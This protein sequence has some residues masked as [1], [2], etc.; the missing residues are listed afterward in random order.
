[1]SPQKSSLFSLHKK[2][3][4]AS[5]PVSQEERRAGS[6]QYDTSSRACPSRMNGLIQSST[7]C[8]CVCV[9]V[10]TCVCVCVC[11]CVFVC[12]C[13]C[14]CLFHISG[15]GGDT[16]SVMHVYRSWRAAWSTVRFVM[17]DFRISCSCSLSR[18]DCCCVWGREGR[19]KGIERE[20]E[21]G[22][23]EKK[24]KRGRGR[25]R[26]REVIKVYQKNIWKRMHFIR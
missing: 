14:V 5:L 16:S 10:R 22:K 17:L 25:E 21:G 1:M 15:R 20:G 9:C 11:V 6:E 26:D 2:Q 3:K 23:E 7:N 12:V 24:G 4:T 8:T 13:V 18:L 19:K